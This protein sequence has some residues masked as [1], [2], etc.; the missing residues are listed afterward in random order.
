MPELPTGLVTFL[1]TDMEGSTRLVAA[2][3]S[4][5]YSTLQEAHR[6]ILRRAIADAQGVELQTAGDAFIA[7]FSSPVG[8]VR[9]AVSGQRGLAEHPWPD[10]GVIRVRMGLHTGRGELTGDDYIGLDVNRA[11]RIAAAG[12]GGQ[13]VISDATRALV[14]RDLPDGVRLRDLGEHR[15]KDLS[16][17][18]RLYQLVIEGLRADFPAL[19]SLE[20]RPNNLP[21]QLTSFVGREKQ[22]TKAVELVAEHRLVTLTGPGGTGKTRL[23]LQTAAEVLPRF[24]DGAF[25]VDLAPLADPAQVSA[26][27][28]QVIGAKEEPGRSLL[29]TLADHLA[30]KELLLI[31]DNF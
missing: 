19:K 12:H 25:F 23:A 5:A 21:L 30:D 28:A 17:P 15:L 14:D 1:F 8:A 7:V 11:A 22:V 18:E 6:A 27:L 29:D 26:A 24:A 9:A 10:D 3:G 20:A 31:L 13:V 2:L 4:E 16:R